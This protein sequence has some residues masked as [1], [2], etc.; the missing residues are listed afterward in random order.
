MITKIF[1]SMIESIMDVSIVLI[2][3]RMIGVE[4]IAQ[5]AWWQP[6]LPML[7]ISGGALIV[8]AIAGILLVTNK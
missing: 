2:V 8:F 7:V 5:W 1:R 4:P 3:L 6:A